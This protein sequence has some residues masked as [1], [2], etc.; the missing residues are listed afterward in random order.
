M[1][2]EE[3]GL[4]TTSAT[5]MRGPWGVAWDT[6]GVTGTGTGFG[7][8]DGGDEVRAVGWGDRDRGDWVCEKNGSEQGADGADDAA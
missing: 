3:G 1:E 6:S 4:V 2:D 7:T 8:V 5:V